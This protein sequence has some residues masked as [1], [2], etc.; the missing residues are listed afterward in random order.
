MARKRP[1]VYMNC[2]DWDNVRKTFA[3]NHVQEVMRERRRMDMYFRRQRFYGGAA[4]V[5]GAILIIVGY[6]LNM[7]MLRGLGMAAGLVGLYLMTTK[8]MII[9]DEYYLECLSRM[10]IL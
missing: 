9:M 8:A 10:M 2:E 7:P 5:A 4:F 6:C 1:E 3:K